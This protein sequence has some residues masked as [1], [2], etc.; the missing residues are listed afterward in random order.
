M[1]TRD[2]I[3]QIR[4]DGGYVKEPLTERSDEDEDHEK[5]DEA[6]PDIG[7]TYYQ[8]KEDENKWLATYPAKI[9]EN[10]EGDMPKRLLYDYEEITL[11][12]VTVSV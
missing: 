2:E 4:E 9:V 7:G 3:Q 10:E 1:H 8:H 6:A 5:I 12:Q 11:E